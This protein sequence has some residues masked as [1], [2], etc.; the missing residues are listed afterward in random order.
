M[1]LFDKV[2]PLDDLAEIVRLANPITAK[3]VT[4]ANIAVDNIKVIDPAV[5]DGFN[6]EAEIRM[7]GVGTAV[8]LVRVRFNRVDLRD[9]VPNASSSE[10][11]RVGVVTAA[12]GRADIVQIAPR[13]SK[14]L[15]TMFDVSG[16]YKDYVNTGTYVVNKGSVTDNYIDINQNSLRYVPGRFYF[17]SFGLGID[18]DAANTNP[19]TV[20]FLNGDGSAL[21]GVNGEIVYKPYLPYM[22]AEGKRS[23]L[24]TIAMCDFTSVWGTNPANVIEQSDIEGQDAYRFNA[25]AFEKINLILSTVGLPPLPR[26]D[27]SNWRVARG[28]N[29]ISPLYPEVDYYLYLHK[30]WYR[31]DYHN[32]ANLHPE[33]TT[34]RDHIVFPYRT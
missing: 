15:G 11:V 32:S 24:M 4:G 12:N 25:E 10:R 28:A 5:N 34:L 29:H 6:T 20:P 3:D 26:P 16:D 7:V 2:N 30:D 17:K 13:I 14:A 33:S 31:S 22:P 18:L 23:A 1:I 9:Y 27:F 19:A 21:Y 8:G